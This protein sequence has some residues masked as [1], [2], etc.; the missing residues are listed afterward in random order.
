MVGLGK[1]LIHGWLV[2]RHKPPL[3]A[4]IVA[5]IGVDLGRA[6]L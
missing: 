2:F 1:G 6:R 5:E 3:I 4:E